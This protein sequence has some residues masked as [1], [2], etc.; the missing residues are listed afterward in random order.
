MQNYQSARNDKA[1]NPTLWDCKL[2]PFFQP[3]LAKEHRKI[4]IA[5]PT[6]PR[7]QP[8]PMPPALRKQLHTADLAF[9][10]ATGGDY[11]KTSLATQFSKT[12]HARRP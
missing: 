12:F 5:L 9:W 3:A 4:R 7:F 2:S 1:V 8:C 6:A 10:E 11:L